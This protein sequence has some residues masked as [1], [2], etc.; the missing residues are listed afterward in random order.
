MIV[1]EEFQSDL[2]ELKELVLKQGELTKIALK[3]SVDALIHQ[4]QDVAEE[5]KLGDNEIDDLEVEINEKIIWMIAKQQPVATD[6]RRLITALKIASEIERNADF[7]VNIAKSVI[8]IGDT[9]LYKPLE[10][11]PKMADEVLIMFDM[12]LNAFKNEDHNLAL[13]MAKMDDKVDDMY[14]KIITELMV[15][16]AKNPDIIA[17]VSELAFVCRY[18]ER[19]ADHTTNI[20]ENIVYL[21]KGK[22]FDLNE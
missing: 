8:R 3:R 1:R 18:L 15:H 14:G 20:G 13:E 6:L 9:P 16:M 22:R 17:Q 5:I 10:D 4:K 11:I 7:A 21:I 19:V 12:A 2:N